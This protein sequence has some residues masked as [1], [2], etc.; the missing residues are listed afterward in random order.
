MDE[1][2]AGE[3]RLIDETLFVE[4]GGAIRLA[5][6]RCLDCT[7]VGF[8]GRPSCAR[9]GSENVRRTALAADGRLWAYTVQRFTPKTPYLGAAATDRPFGVGY[10]DLGGEVLV[11]SR[12]VGDLSRLRPGRRMRLTLDELPGADGRPVFTFAFQPDDD[13]G[14]S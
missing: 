1:L 2:I 5:G 4:D 13:S 12:L 11:E 3:R 7:T 14:A 9:C 6:S 10:V 8:P